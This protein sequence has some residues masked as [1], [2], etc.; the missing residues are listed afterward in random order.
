LLDEWKMSLMD[1]YDVPSHTPLLWYLGIRA[2][3]VFFKNHQRYPGMINDWESDVPVLQENYK[4][5]ALHYQLQD[6]QL[7]QENAV[8]ICQ[9]LTRYANAE[10]HT[11]ASVVGGV[12]SQE[13]V[14][15]ITGQYTPLNNTYV[16]NGIVSVAG[17]YK[18]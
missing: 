5:V 2:C 8:A 15:I 17:V 1:P 9:E 16:F 3:Q 4:Q 11:I 10:I 7:V 14:K 18:F 13:A 12:A 6:E